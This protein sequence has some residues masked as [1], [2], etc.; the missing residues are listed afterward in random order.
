MSRK[1]IIAIG[2]IFLVA[3]GRA[4]EEVTAEGVNKDSGVQTEEFITEPVFPI[5]LTD[6]QNIE[7]FRKFK[8]VLEHENTKRF[9]GD[10]LR[11]TFDLNGKPSHQLH[12]STLELYQLGLKIID[13]K[14]ELAELYMYGLREEIV[15]MSHSG[16]IRG[17]IDRI[18]EKLGRSY[19]FGVV[20]E[21]MQFLM[22]GLDDKNIEVLRNVLNVNDKTSERAEMLHQKLL[23]SEN[24]Y[25]DVE[26]TKLITEAIYYY[27]VMKITGSLDIRLGL[28]QLGTRFSDEA[29]DAA[30]I[31]RAR[32]KIKF[33]QEHDERRK[34]LNRMIDMANSIN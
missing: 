2:L 17:Q 5:K 24:D 9:L 16:N 8:A 34:R 19:I 18:T 13:R 33:N 7:F 4:S 23:P 22:E 15:A 3:C 26:T 30:R 29:F 25:K 6:A 27:Q 31:T 12:P 21:P 10:E 32:L 14:P 11:L 1:V 28:H 20:N